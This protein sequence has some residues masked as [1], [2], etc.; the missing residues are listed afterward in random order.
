M[1][2]LHTILREA[3]QR[4]TRLKRTIKKQQR[5][6]LQILIAGYTALALAGFTLGIIISL[7]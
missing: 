4:N 5:E 6:K 7:I 3:E 2:V 1:T